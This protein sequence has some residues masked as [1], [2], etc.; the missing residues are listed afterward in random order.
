MEREVDRYQARESGDD[1]YLEHDLLL[2]RLCRTNQSSS[3][4]A[5]ECHHLSLLG[6]VSYTQMIFGKSTINLSTKDIYSHLQAND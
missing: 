1:W 4:V 3:V 2:A 6:Y 5:S